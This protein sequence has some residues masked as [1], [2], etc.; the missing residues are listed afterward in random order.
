MY[1]YI[2]YFPYFPSCFQQCFLH[3]VASITRQWALQSLV[4]EKDL[5]L[6]ASAL[7]THESNL[8][9][10]SNIPGFCGL[11]KRQQNC[12][13]YIQFPLFKFQGLPEQ[14]ELL[15]HPD[16]KYSKKEQHFLDW[17]IFSSIKCKCKHWLLSSEC[18][19]VHS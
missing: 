9:E 14:R 10:R 2:L 7:Q 19:C 1:H 11:Q 8:A 6:R 3:L 12:L 4:D 15:G 18:C 16:H 5:F 17:L 13:Y